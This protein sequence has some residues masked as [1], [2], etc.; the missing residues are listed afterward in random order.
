MMIMMMMKMTMMHQLVMNKELVRSITFLL[1]QNLK[2]ITSEV[3]RIIMYFEK[4]LL[5]K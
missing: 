2:A 5:R 1:I 4:I 3:K